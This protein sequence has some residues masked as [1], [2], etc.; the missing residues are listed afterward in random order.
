MIKTIKVPKDTEIVAF[1]DP[2]EHAEQFFNL[3][4]IINPSEKKWIVCCGDLKDKGYGDVAFNNM[5]DEMIKLSEKG[6]GFIVKGNHE[7]KLLKNNRKNSNASLQIEWWRKQSLGLSFEFYNGNR[8]TVLHAGVVPGM[9][10]ED[11]DSNTEVAY[12]R[13][14]DELGMIQLIWKKINGVDTLVK[15]REGGKS[16]HELYQGNFGYVVSGHQPNK[17]GQ[18]RYY[19]Y[20]CNLDCAV[21]E[22]GV[23]RAQ[24]FTPEGN[25]G[26]LITVTGTAFKPKLNEKF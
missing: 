10:W 15:S 12:V 5:T 18:P 14:V 23:L 13:D 2:H 26:E 4:N 3:L 17:D 24:T 9:T 8:L 16:W 25:L 22:T 6:I 1:T 7:I 19:N 20:S 11:L 21:F